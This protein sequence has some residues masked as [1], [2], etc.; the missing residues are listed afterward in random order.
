M[1]ERETESERGLAETWE[2]LIYGVR[3]LTLFPRW[4]HTCD[5]D[6]SPIRARPSIKNYETMR[7]PRV[8]DGPAGLV[9]IRHGRL[10]RSESSD[11]A[12][13]PSTTIALQRC[14]TRYAAAIIRKPRGRARYVGRPWPHLAYDSGRFCG[15]RWSARPCFEK[16]LTQRSGPLEALMRLIKM[17]KN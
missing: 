9:Y 6:A 12:S 3:P 15:V 14:R 10:V 11:I 8:L 7:P 5:Q 2:H 16:F 17:L 1:I 4:S 13:E